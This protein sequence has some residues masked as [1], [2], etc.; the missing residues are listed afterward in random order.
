[1]VRLVTLEKR[2]GLIGARLAGA[3]DATGPVLV[4]LDSHTE[5]NV[6]WLPP[7]L[8]WIFFCLDQL[9]FGTGANTFSY[10]DQN[11]KLMSREF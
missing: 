11:M 2:K 7:L 6:N 10:L 5:C 3:Q 9:V 4:F 8:G 1:M